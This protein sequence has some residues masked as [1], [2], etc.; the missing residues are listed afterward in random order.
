ME[1]V[2]TKTG[3]SFNVGEDSFYWATEYDDSEDI[4]DR[5]D[6]VAR[7]YADCQLR[8]LQCG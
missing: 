8:S 3:Y 7:A 5:A 1:G 6:A 2:V 4:Y